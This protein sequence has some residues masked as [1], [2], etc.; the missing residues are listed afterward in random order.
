MSDK[1]SFIDEL[2][3]RNVVRMAGLYLVGPWLLIRVAEM[4]L[5]VFASGNI[6]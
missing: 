4:G 3:W 6:R 1:P 2:K 5:P